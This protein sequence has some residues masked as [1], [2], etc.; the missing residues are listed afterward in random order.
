[1]EQEQIAQLAGF[2]LLLVGGAGG[3]GAVDLIDW[4]KEKLKLSGNGALLVTAAVATVIAILTLMIDGQLT[5]GGVNWET[6]PYVA[7]LVFVAAQAR[8]RMLRDK[9]A[10]QE[11]ARVRLIAAVAQEMAGEAMAEAQGTAVVV[12]DGGTVTAER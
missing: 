2:V 3:A 7:G 12:N 9:A 8:F 5:P 10:G 11:V 6:L 4:L 1:M